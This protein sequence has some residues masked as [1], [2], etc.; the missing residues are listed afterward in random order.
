V[1]QSTP[2]PEQLVAV[3]AQVLDL[4]CALADQHLA[5]QVRRCGAVLPPRRF[6]GAQRQRQAGT[7]DA[8]QAHSTQARRD[9]RPG[10]AG[11]ACLGEPIGSHSRA[12]AW[13]HT[14]HQHAVAW[15]VC[16]ARSLACT[17]D[18]AARSAAS[19]R[20]AGRQCP[21]FSMIYIM[22]RAAGSPAARRPALRK[23]ILPQRNV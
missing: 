13:A 15:L 12:A 22:P 2:Q 9:S 19:H 17:L 5:Q 11:Q 23:D 4:G 3:P 1:P 14:S 18:A 21:V 10:T 7:T 8:A 6:A 16:S 20:S